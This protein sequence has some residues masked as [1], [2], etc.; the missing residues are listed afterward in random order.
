MN[1]QVKDQVFYMF[2]H[3]ENEEFQIVGIENFIQWLNDYDDN[4][5]FSLKGFDFDKRRA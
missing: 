2:D 3:N 4:F 1:N 5:S